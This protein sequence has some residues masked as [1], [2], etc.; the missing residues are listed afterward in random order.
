MR[1]STALDPDWSGRWM[2]SQTEGSSACARTT[3]SRGSFGCGVVERVRAIPAIRSPPPPGD[4]LPPPQEVGE[5]VAALLRQ[6]APVAVHVLAKERHLAH[7]VRR[8]PLDL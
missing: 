7:P 2:C 8:E 5:G 3:S 4:R 1:F 6:V